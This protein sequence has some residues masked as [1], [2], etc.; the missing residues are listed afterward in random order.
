MSTEKL[1]YIY[2]GRGG[3]SLLFT[4]CTKVFL[5]GRRFEEFR[6]VTADYTIIKFADKPSHISS[7]NQS[8]AS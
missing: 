1:F 3:H 2:C 6:K 5:H 4:V 8:A 7:R